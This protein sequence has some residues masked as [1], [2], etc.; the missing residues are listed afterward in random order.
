MELK[1]TILKPEPKEKTSSRGYAA[2]AVLA[3]GLA[4]LPSSVS[5]QNPDG[6]S[7][8]LKA[9]TIALDV[10]VA[11]IAKGRSGD[12]DLAQLAKQTASRSDK[13]MSVGEL[14]QNKKV[15]IAGRS[16][17]HVSAPLIQLKKGRQVV[18][19]GDSILKIK[20][21]FETG[22]FEVKVAKIDAKGVEL[23][24][25]MQ[26][27]MSESASNDKTHG[28]STMAKPRIF[29]PYFNLSPTLRIKA[30]K[31]SK[32]G[33]AVIIIGHLFDESPY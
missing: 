20:L 7:P 17:G 12:A 2:A 28:G 14:E 22:S 16:V 25:N 13:A 27:S 1:R 31:G 5:A 6:G 30:E 23:G 10:S 9:A 26:I 33:T 8:K 32:P 29:P 18:K 15:V 4:I 3:A 21:V 11:Q 24:M 19:K